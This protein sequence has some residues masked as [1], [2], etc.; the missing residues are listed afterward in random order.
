MVYVA[1]LRGINVGGKNKVDMKLL[2]KAFEEVGM[3]SV[4]TYINSGNV[5]FTVEDLSKTEIA[6]MLEDVIYTVFGLTIKVLIRSLDDIKKMMQTL[7]DSWTNDQSMRSEVLFLWEDIDDE[8]IMDKLILK[9]DID[10]VKYVSGAILW[11]IDRKD[12]TKSGIGKFIGTKIYKQMT[13]RNI[14]TT[15]KIYE[16]M[17]RAA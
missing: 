3:R 12:V 6:G 17:L 10:K 4:V 7:P 13:I 8:T 2:K 11:S 5:I 14:N 9:P 15:R 1:L 16:L